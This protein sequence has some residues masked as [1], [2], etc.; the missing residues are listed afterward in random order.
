M[1]RRP[2]GRIN[3]RTASNAALGV[4]AILVYVFADELRSVRLYAFSHK[5]LEAGTLIFNLLW[6][7][8]HMVAK[9]G[10]KAIGAK[11]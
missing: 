10:G 5:V 4:L 1:I 9:D 2:D 11:P 6:S 8:R 3:G 7:G